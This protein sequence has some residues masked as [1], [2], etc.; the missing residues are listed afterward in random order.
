MDDKIKWG[1]LGCGK[2]AHKF[3]YDLK[4]SH[5]GYLY[6]CASRDASKAKSFAQHFGASQYFDNYESL[7]NC[8][9]LDAV[10]IATPH[11]LHFD[12][13]QLCINAHKHVM[14]EKPITTNAD[15]TQYLY[16]LAKRKKVLL[17]EAMWTAF[18]P[19]I[20]EVKRRT[21]EN[22]I[23][24]IRYITADFGF[25]SSFD[26]ES[27]LYNKNLAGGTLLDI[28]IYPLFITLYLLGYPDDIV[29]TATMS[30]TGV[31]E[32]C[33]MMVKYK[34]GTTAALYSSVTTQTDT[35]CE[36]FGTEG[37]ILIPDRFHGQSGYHIVTQS[38]NKWVEAGKIGYGYYH[39]IEHFNK[40]I[41]QNL[42]ESPVMTAQI[43]ISLAKMMDKVKLQLGLTYPWE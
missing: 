24:Q 42:N 20:A 10:Y 38:E 21:S 36:I 6:A 31:D 35:K 37:K 11:S 13:C 22:S 14:C 19:A 33:T 1:I 29:A 17:M 2:I 15:N 34:N 12:H 25:K 39:E 8:K 41:K 4:H 3:A 30:P 5:T 32:E 28:G 26:K 9:E 18:L 16:E 40:C 7:V 27:R 23:G 43:S